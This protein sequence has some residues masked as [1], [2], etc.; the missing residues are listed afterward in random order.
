MHYGLSV[1]AISSLWVSALPLWLS[2]L[3]SLLIVL[4]GY[5]VYQAK[6]RCQPQRLNWRAGDEFL[7]W[8]YTGQF[9]SLHLPR[10]HRQGAWWIISGVDSRQRIQRILISP[11][12]ITACQQRQLALLA[13]IPNKEKLS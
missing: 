3:L 10:C 1:L 11:D 2:I 9:E 5:T 6:Q 8:N 7:L 12:M 13:A 4:N